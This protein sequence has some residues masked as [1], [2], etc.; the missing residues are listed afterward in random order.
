MTWRLLAPLS[1]R[2]LSSS[3]G[4]DPF[5]LMQRELGRVFDD[6]YSGF[7]AGTLPTGM[8]RLDVKEDEQAFHVTADL[9]GLSEKDVDLSFEDGILTV[10]GEKKIERD[11]KKDTW[12]IT[13]RSHGS[14]SRQLSLPATID[15]EKIT[16]SFEKGVLTVTLPKQPEERA[17]AKKIEV[18]AS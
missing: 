6:L 13:E 12:H 1:G 3:S 8:L 16:A 4:S 11:E 14:F 5:S 2:A 18:K 15:A 17:K 7:P 9:P 10:R